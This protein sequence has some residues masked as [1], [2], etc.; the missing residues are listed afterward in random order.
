MDWVSAAMM[1]A[2][3]LAL[4]RMTFGEEADERVMSGVGALDDL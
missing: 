1:F 4:I 2:F 3:W